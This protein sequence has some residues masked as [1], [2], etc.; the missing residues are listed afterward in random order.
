MA[1]LM[2]PGPTNIPQRIKDALS[3]DPLPHREKEFVDLFLRTCE[4]LR[5]VFGCSKG[6]TLILGGTGTA[7]M[8]ASLVS[9]FGPGERVVNVVSG[10]FSQR[11]S[12]IA[13]AHGLDAGVLDV[14]WGTRVPVEQVK[15]TV[16]NEGA[17]GVTMV[18]NETSTGVSNAREVKEVGRFMR[19]RGGFLIV[20]AI[21]SL[22]GM[23]M[24]MDAWDVDA[25]VSAGQKCFMLPPGIAF[26]G[27]SRRAIEKMRGRKHRGYYLDPLAYIEDKG[28]AP[29]TP[30]V[31]AVYALEASL[32]IMEEE[33]LENRYTRHRDL[34]AHT[35]QR[36]DDLGLEFFPERIDIMSDVVTALKVK[37]F[38]ERSLRGRLAREHGIYI[39]GGQDRLRGRIIRVAH[40]GMVTREHVE[41]TM[42]AIGS[43]LP[44]VMS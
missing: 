10:K 1:L 5:P 16:E 30:P 19:G 3:R 40:M 11:F 28:R 13:K 34:A 12:D 17:V 38:D 21:S 27:L 26:M 33:G 7:V 31:N 37:G 15:E 20:D 42:E 29:Y 32:D 23:R 6:E 2:I 43:V 18:H 24:D 22:G 25:C 36:A 44:E 35:R 39:A 14:E 4:R 41:R 8:E 9:M